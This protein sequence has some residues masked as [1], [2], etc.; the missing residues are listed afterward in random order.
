[1][2][3]WSHHT[4]AQQAHPDAFVQQS[5]VDRR[6]KIV[7]EDVVLCIQACVVLQCQLRGST[8]PLQAQ[9][10]EIDP[11]LG[12]EFV[13]ERLRLARRAQHRVH[14]VQT[15]AHRVQDARKEDAMVDLTAFFVALRRTR[16]LFLQLVRC[17]QQPRHGSGRQCDKFFDAQMSSATRGEARIQLFSV[18]SHE[19]EANPA[20]RPVDLL[21]PLV[22]LCVAQWLRRHFAQ[23]GLPRRNVCIQYLNV[24][25]SAPH[26]L[27]LTTQPA[28]QARLH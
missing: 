25:V 22:L 7:D 9:R 23:Q 10:R 20:A 2:P 14:Q 19:R 5:K 17:R 15:A 12:A 21:G 4:A 1:L 6:F 27:R 24:G 28:L 16:L 13:Q 8:A 3:S 18:G 11:A 26:V